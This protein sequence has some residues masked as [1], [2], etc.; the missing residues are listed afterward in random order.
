M[1]RKSGFIS[2]VYFKIAENTEWDVDLL[3]L[4]SLHEY[5]DLERAYLTYIKS[6][7]SWNDGLGR[8]SSFTWIIVQ[9][10][11]FYV[12][13]IFFSFVLPSACGYN[14]YIIIVGMQISKT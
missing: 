3:I 13:N 2:M 5:E 14:F 11:C 10:T 8:V 1:F 9:I 6:I 7:N 4:C 12:I